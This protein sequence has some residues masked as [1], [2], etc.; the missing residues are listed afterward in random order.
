MHEI[1]VPRGISESGMQFPTSGDFFKP[2]TTL[3]PTFKPLSATIY[4]FSL[5]SNFVKAIN[6]DLFG[7]YSIDKTSATSS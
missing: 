6:A 1:I 5:S 3:S 7:S 4:L 2:E